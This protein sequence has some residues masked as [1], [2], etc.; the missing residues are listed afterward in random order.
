MINRIE[1]LIEQIGETRDFTNR[2]ISEIPRELWFEIP[3]HTD[4]NFAWQIGHLI[5]SQNFH[6]ITVVHG[7]NPKVFDTMPI[8]KYIRSFYG[9]GTEHRSIE[10]GIYPATQ[11]HDHFDLI[12]QITLDLLETFPEKKLNDPLEPI[13]LKHPLAT[14]KYEALSWSFKHEM[15]HC[16]E[17]EMVKRL[18]GR[19][20]K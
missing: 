5:V 6:C 19:P 11:L 12:Q 8:M 4:M 9:M 16:A 18:I 13:P 20:I 3:E 1:F 15:W 17:M 2:L 7:K 14:T 10:E